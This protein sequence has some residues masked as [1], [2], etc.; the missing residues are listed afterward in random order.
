MPTPSV[1]SQSTLSQAPPST[2]AAVPSVASVRNV[3]LI[4]T[5]LIFDS[6]HFIWARLLLQ[7]LPPSVSV[8]YVL[9]I[10][11]VEVGLFGV[12]RGSLHWRAIRRHFWFFLA[13]GLLIAA[14]TTINYEA[15]A[16]IDPGTASLLSQTAVLFSLGFGIL[17]LKDHLSRQQIVGALLALVGVFITSF[18]P[19]DY[20]R[21][22]AL[23][24]VASAFMYALHAALTKRY[25]GKMNLVTFFFYRLLFT[26]GVL[27]V[28]ATA[29][30]LLIWPAPGTWGL[31]FAVGTVD[32]VLSRALYYLA[33]R[34]LT[35]SVH[36]IV[37]TLSP[38][39][40]TLWALLIFGTLPTVQQMLGGLAILTGV[41]V[42]SLNR[43]PSHHEDDATPT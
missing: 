6:L 24:T 10:S 40:A 11:A 15:V 19:G 30:G 38:V 20:L 4:G 25:G 3:P 12:A 18:Q 21:L 5:L 17:W 13:I 7:Y 36:T 14:S 2:T 39:A 37:L 43:V 16:F 42:V 1:P 28:F 22:G 41:L 29:R 35:I 33:L 34:R 27:A 23:L 9:G 26:T 8:L 31:L 32:V